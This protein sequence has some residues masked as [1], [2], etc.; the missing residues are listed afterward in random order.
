MTVRI[1]HTL[2]EVLREESPAKARITHTLGEVL[3]VYVP[4]DWLI[5]DIELRFYT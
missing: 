2:G 3:R 4:C 1:T 5:E